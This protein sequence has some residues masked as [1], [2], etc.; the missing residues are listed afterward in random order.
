MRATEKSGEAKLLKVY[1]DVRFRVKHSVAESIKRRPY[2]R[3]I[4]RVE[5]R[6]YNAARIRREIARFEY[7]PKISVIVPVY[8][9]PLEILDLAIRSVRKQLYENW[10]LC[11]CD[12]ASPNG[13][14]KECLEKWL[15]RDAR[16]KVNFSGRN[17]GISGASN[18]ALRLASGEFI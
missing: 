4:R 11:I 1:R 14:V 15:K 7:Q 12:D 5:Q 17:E 16:I 6:S 9:T 2:E 13:R 3:W 8:N 18:Q 10:E